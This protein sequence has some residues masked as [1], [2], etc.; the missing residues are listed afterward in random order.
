MGTLTIRRC[1]LLIL[2]QSTRLSLRK[3]STEADAVSVAMHSAYDTSH[4]FFHAQKCA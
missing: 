4:D 1:A 3:V 2:L